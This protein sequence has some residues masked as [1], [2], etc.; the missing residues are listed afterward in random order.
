MYRYIHTCIS[1]HIS[2]P[3]AYTHTHICTN[4]Y[5]MYTWTHANHVWNDGAAATARAAQLDIKKFCPSPFPHHDSAPS[6]PHPLICAGAE[7]IHPVQ[8]PCQ[9][10]AWPC[11]PMAPWNEVIFLPFWRVLFGE[12]LLWK[13]A[14]LKQEYRLSLRNPRKQER[15]ELQ[16][17]SLHAWSQTESG[18]LRAVVEIFYESDA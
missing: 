2:F 10:Q 9:L 5:K 18:K 14:S 6:R 11:Q 12:S 7:P 8:Y 16:R 15:K 1:I 17:A 3:H 13:N 4:A